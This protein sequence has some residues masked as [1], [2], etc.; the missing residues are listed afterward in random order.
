MISFLKLKIPPWKRDFQLEVSLPKSQFKNPCRG[1]TLVELLVV[2]SIIGLLSST[3]LA[4]LNGARAKARDAAR[5]QDFSQVRTALELYYDKYAAYPLASG[6]GISY[7]FS[8]SSSPL[9]AWSGL[10]GAL[11][12]FIPKLSIDPINQ[13]NNAPMWFN[14]Y[15]Y[16]Y[17]VNSDGSAY[18]LIAQLETQHPLRCSIKRWISYVRAVGLVWCDPS[19]APNLSENIYADH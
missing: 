15:G 12:E 2:I 3:V 1:F 7:R 4:A 10:E 6:V 16:S 9:N 13:T 19:P 18:D 17:A 5:I 14:G 11:S 8:K